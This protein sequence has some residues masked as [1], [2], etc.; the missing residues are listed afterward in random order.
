MGAMMV[1]KNKKPREGRICLL[2]GGEGEI[3]THGTVE[4][5]ARF[6]VWCIRP[7]CHLSAGPFALLNNSYKRTRIIAGHLRYVEIWMRSSAKARI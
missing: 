6:R 4:P 1:R 3:R 2:L 7:L 5:Y